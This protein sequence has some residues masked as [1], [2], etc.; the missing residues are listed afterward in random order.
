MEK[1][2]GIG[3]GTPGP[4]RRKGVPNKLTI[5]AR[6]AIQASFDELGGVA[7]LT[8]WARKNPTEFYRLYARLIPIEANVEV[9]QRVIIIDDIVPAA[10]Y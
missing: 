4:G 8:A 3:K 2:A 7:A 6:L 1:Q 10:Q 5:G 9:A